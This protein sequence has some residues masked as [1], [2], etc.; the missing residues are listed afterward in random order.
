MTDTTTN[1]ATMSTLVHP[2]LED[3]RLDGRPTAAADELAW[4]MVP[5]S[6]FP[7][8]PGGEP[9]LTGQV[10][11]PPV[12]AGPARRTSPWRV[13]AAATVVASLAGGVTGWAAA[14]ATTSTTTP[15]AVVASGSASA[16][17][18]GASTPDV[19]AA[20]QPSVVT[21]DVTSNAST[22]NGRTV[23]QSAAGTGFV[24][25]ANGLIATNAHV[26]AGATS[27]TVTLAD[28]TEVAGTVVGT[29]A[30]ADL[31]VVKIDRTGLT[32][33]AIGSSTAL[34][35]GDTVIAIG[36]ALGLS[37]SPT[38]TMGIVSALG[39][40][41]TTDSGTSYQDLVQID[42]PINPGDSGGPVVD[43]AGR[44]IGIASAGT[45]TAENIGFA[46][47][48]DAAMPILTALA[49]A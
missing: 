8:A 33:A 38:A 46:I 32:P 14:R 2:D 3:P 25:D 40:S 7:F 30:T 36:N 37:G 43:A 23:A 4:P 20:V 16:L 28:G 1:G 15:A 41:I 35:V 26:V 39:R 18:A 48:I 22:R 21:I 44:V 27:V 47:P 24:I 45:T 19:I 34:R 5:P 10:A 13:L 42:A 9:P 12:P 31:A 49:T 29:D 6:P 11:R 17:A